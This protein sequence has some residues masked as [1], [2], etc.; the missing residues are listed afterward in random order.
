[1][2]KQ[3]PFIGHHFGV[4]FL[5]PKFNLNAEFTE[6]SGLNFTSGAATQKEGGNPGFSHRL[7]DHGTFSDLTLKRG[8]TDDMGLYEW[9]E[10]THATMKTQP[11]NILV[12]LLD[13]HEIPVKNW[14]IFHAIPKSWDGGSLSVTNS[15]VM[16]ESVSFSY[17]NFILI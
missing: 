7:T 16:M 10:G 9:C 1:M 6:V 5:F 13:K 15:S 12:S 2:P 14:L 8:F 4:H 3:F 17:Q 11:C